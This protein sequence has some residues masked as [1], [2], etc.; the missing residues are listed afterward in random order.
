[1][2]TTSLSAATLSQLPPTVRRP[3]YDRSKVTPGIVH[4][5]IGA[6]SRAHLAVYT[7]DRLAAGE[8]SWGLIGVD[9]MGPPL[10]DVLNAQD[11][12]YTLVVRE[13]KGDAPRVIG[14]IVGAY[15]LPDD[16]QAVLAQM[17]DAATRIVTITVSEKGY[18]QDAATGNLDE[19]HPL[20]VAD[21]ANP[22]APRS[23]PGLVTEALVRRRAA[24]LP[25]FT[26]LSCDNLSENGIKARRIVTRFATLRDA[27]LGK[28]VSEKVAFPCTMVDRITPA[29]TDEVRAS[30]SALIG[31]TDGWPVATEPFIQWVIED[32]FPLGRPAWEKAG[33]T[34]VSD[35]L[36]FEMMKLRCLNG[37]HSALA[38]L[39]TLLGLETVYD[40]MSDKLCGAFVHRLWP[41]DLA[42]TV[43][44]IPGIDVADYT[45]QLEERFLNPRIRH[46]TI[47]ISSDGS[48]KLPP[49]LLEPALEQLKAGAQP[50]CVAFL[51]A[52]WMRFLSGVNEAGKSYKIADPM[53]A[54]LTA[55]AADKGRNAKALAEALF[56]VS[57]IFTPE[58]LGFASFRQDVVANLTAIFE[59]GTAKA[60]ER[61][62]AV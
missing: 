50:R 25:P 61:F 55:I 9:P 35:V 54:S 22:T 4:I 2:S 48:Q 39:G 13:A 31:M 1:M 52:A 53:A 32:N 34:M 29:T 15:C 21:L 57:D 27:E 5:G 38:Y 19:R 33:A 36:P 43:P 16:T 44:P 46:L 24:G 60:L 28:F 45:R 7:D 49:R 23:V 40:A 59:L 6:F 17:A 12:L 10:R 62:L 30:A 18:C 47:Q 11:G 58:L 56:G 42:P 41:E 3:A 14:S 51:V 20:I 8:T 37:S 26:V